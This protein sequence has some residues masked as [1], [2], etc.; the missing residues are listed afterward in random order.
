MSETSKK[1]K[2]SKKELFRILKYALISCSAG[3]IQ[4]IVSTILRL[5]ILP[6]MIDPTITMTFIT[7]PY[8]VSFVGETIGLAL[9][10][11]WNF[12]F[13]RKFTFKSA[14]NIPI[15]MLLAFAFYIPFY[16]FQIWYMNLVEK[17]LEGSIGDWAFIISLVT[18]MTINGVLEFCWQQ[19]VVF[20]GTLDS[21]AKAKQEQEQQGELAEQPEQ[22]DVNEAAAV[23]SER[24]SQTDVETK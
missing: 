5:W 23:E 9:S 18:C 4:F 21:N 17:G 10:I 7:E 1:P 8:V 20:R 19:F 24:Q 6:Y 12:T 14:N 16:P 15:A 11:V 3:A 13:N 2:I 22:A